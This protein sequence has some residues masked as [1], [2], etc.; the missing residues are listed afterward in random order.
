MLRT[1]RRVADGFD[2]GSL[3]GSVDGT[4][5][6]SIQ[7]GAHRGHVYAGEVGSSYRSTYTVMGDTVNL[8]ARLMGAAPAGSIY[9]TPD[10]LDETRTSFAT[11]P[12]APLRVK[13]KAQ[14]QA[15]VSLGDMEGM[16]KTAPVHTSPFVGRTHE[17]QQLTSL[18]LA[19]AAGSGQV[20][21][22]FGDAGQGK[23]RLA[24]EAVAAVPSSLVMVARGEPS[25]LAAYG[26]VQ[27]VVR[28]AVGIV[29]GPPEQQAKA[30]RRRVR[31]LAPDLLPLLPLIGTAAHVSVPMTPEVEALELRFRPD[32]LADCVLR[33]LE[34][35]QPGPLVIVAEDAQWLD[36]GSA[37][38]IAAIATA[39]CAH[40]WALITIRRPEEGAAQPDGVR[41]E[42]GP[43]PDEEMWDLLLAATADAPRRTHDLEAVA[44]R[45]GG[46][47]LFALELLAVAGAS[48]DGA[49][50]P[51]SIE[52]VAAFQLDRLPPH[53]RARLR[54]A[55][56]LGTRFPIT[57]FEE[58]LDE[59]DIS[60][61]AIVDDL[62][63]FL[64]RDREEGWLRFRLAVHRD[65]AYQGMSYARRRELHRRAAEAIERNTAPDPDRAAHRLAR[66]WAAANVYDRAWRYGRVAAERAEA[67]YSN[68]EAVELYRLALEAVR[69]LGD[70]DAREQARVWGQLGDVLG[71]SGRFA[72]GLA[73]YR[74]AALLMEN[75]PVATAALWLRRA[76]SHERAGAYRS[77][78]RDLASGR[79]ALVGIET[80]KA[81]RVRAGLLAFSAL[82]REA[83][84]RPGLA[85]RSAEEAIEAARAAGD[86]QALARASL[87][88]SWALRVLGKPGSI[89]PLE[90]ARRIFAKDADLAG[91]AIATAN[92]GAFHYFDGRWDDAV[93]AYGAAIEVF[94]RIG[95]EVQAAVT[96]A[97]LGEVLVNQ[98]RWTE[99]EP[100]LRD[101]SRVLQASGFDDGV[102]FAEMHLAR[103]FAGLGDVGR[104]EELLTRVRSELLAL[105]K[106]TSALE[107]TI[108]LA[109]CRLAA[110]DAA[111][112]L[113]TLDGSARPSKDAA[114]L[115][116]P[117]ARVRWRALLALGRSVEAED[118]RSSALSEARNGGMPYELAL[119]L[120]DGR[121]DP[122]AA[123]LLRSL[124]VC[125]RR[126]EPRAPGAAWSPKERQRRNLGSPAPK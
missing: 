103:I 77:A 11:T 93:S 13:G 74:R 105:G 122:E 6:I 94:H 124:G 106:A 45:A 120:D 8:A 102:T 48:D 98:R 2:D 63:G 70:V 86:R 36:D 37:H 114:L 71:N 78:L 73:A 16:T 61:D 80:R 56:V 51:G 22:V 47:P 107:V 89:A 41:I 33:L 88:L 35:G 92:L 1:L 126:R 125:E 96:A 79:R 31:E 10:V 46:N 32:R 15:A 104:A 43:L 91:Q 110:G 100:V 23:S 4:G 87:V 18:L 52:A 112:A 57:A 26:A 28:Q 9:V 116:V 81:R 90:E 108:Y 119:L 58:L 83:Q 84:E 40:P 25:G 101:A 76:R 64:Q 85:V 12:I 14:P 54:E 59:S 62:E 49:A 66:H 3:G 17:L 117:F 42:V 50:V 72:D 68:P 55:S 97:N 19:A 121:G 75:D 20:V 113:A 95:D 7:L 44:A 69:H 38:L 21:D 5:G 39:A 24:A 118:E 29:P 27:E 123:D 67:A 53:A 109:E 115:A 65:A 99:A 60:V 111:G 82:V 34:A 30:L